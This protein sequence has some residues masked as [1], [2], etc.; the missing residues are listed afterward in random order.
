VSEQSHKSEMNDAVRGDFERLRA[1]RQW[2][3]RAGE[4]PATPQPERIV[5]TPPQRAEEPE[6]SHVEPPAA[7]QEAPAPPERRSWLRS[8]LRR[9]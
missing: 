2:R 6:A 8:V 7:P 5:L 1:R 9:D 3:G 4:R